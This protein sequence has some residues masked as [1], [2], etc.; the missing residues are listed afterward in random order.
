MDNPQAQRAMELFQSGYCCAE[1]VLL[2]LAE[3]SEI[4]SEIIPQIATGFCSGVARTGDMCG[5]VAGAIMGIGLKH[6]RKTPEDPREQ[7][8]QMI[9][10]LLEQ[11]NE[12]FGGTTCLAL[13]G[14]RLDTEEGQA[15][16]KAK[17]TTQ[18]YAQYVGYAT[19]LVIDLSE[20][21]PDR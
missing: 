18:Q 9:R 10:S 8:Y 19:R 3:Y 12:R 1:C 4:D 15:Q 6:G 17:Q 7:C 11:F 16:Y 20:E 2:A 13:T 14:V 5:A 21:N